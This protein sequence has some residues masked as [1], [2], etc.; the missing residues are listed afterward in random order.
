MGLYLKDG[1]GGQDVGIMTGCPFYLTISLERKFW[2]EGGGR[3]GLFKKN[4]QRKKEKKKRS[5]MLEI[6]GHNVVVK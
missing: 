1:R 3:L 2:K 4:K 5:N 6:A